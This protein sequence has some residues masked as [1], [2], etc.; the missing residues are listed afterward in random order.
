MPL[1]DIETRVIKTCCDLNDKFILNIVEND[2]LFVY[3]SRFLAVDFNK[4]FIIIDEPS[5]ETPDAIPLSK[6]Q[7]FEIYFE[8]K[9]LRYLFNS[10]VLEL[11]EYKLHQQSLHALKI[12]LPPQL[13]DGNNRDYFRVI[14]GMK[15]PIEVK[16]NIEN[17][18]GEFAGK[19]V[20]ISG[21]GFAMKVKMGDKPVLLEKGDTINAR[22]KLKPGDEL[23]EIWSEVR[24]IREYED[25]RIVVLGMKFLGKERSRNLN[26]YRNK[27]L[28]YVT[29]RQREIL[30][31]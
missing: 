4:G 26:Y 24:N 30:L 28:R 8:Y 12:L 11:T 22:F 20:D 16:F 19:I 29:E 7:S 13:L 5:P 23:W 6:G 14:P 15:P 27:I 25:T 3:K 31:K 2:R 10:K 21:E 1:T 9:T 17:T 18:P